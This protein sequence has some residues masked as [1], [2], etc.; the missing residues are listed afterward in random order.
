MCARRSKHYHHGNLRQVLIDEGTRLLDA[1]G[2]TRFSLRE[3]AKAACVSHGAPYRHFHDR[4]ALL[5]AIAAQGFANLEQACR[6]ATATH[7][8]DPR[9][10]LLMAGRG[11]IAFALTHPGVLHI[12]FGGGLRLDGAGPVFR[13]AA[14]AAFAHLVDIVERGRQAGLYRD[15]SA[16][17]LTVAAW[18]MAH[19]LSLLLSAGPLQG[20]R[21]DPAELEALISSIGDS[22][23][24]GLVARP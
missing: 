1:Q 7:P 13:E 22:L 17:N 20:V 24:S 6:A 9:A 19:G 5:E 18:S 12:M 4:T 15:D 14:A 16:E 23:L 8:H 10:Q 2:V 3:V 11:Y 21:N